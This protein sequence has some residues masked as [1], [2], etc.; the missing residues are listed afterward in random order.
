MARRFGEPGALAVSPSTRSFGAEGALTVDSPSLL[1]RRDA[2][3][4]LADDQRVER[5]LYKRT[6]RGLNRRLRK[7]DTAAGQEAIE[8]LN[9]GRAAGIQMTG[10][11]SANHDFNYAG[12]RLLDS[13]RAAAGAEEVTSGTGVTPATGTPGGT[14]SAPPAPGAPTTGA[15]G[16]AS[17]VIAGADDGGRYEGEAR[18]V[19]DRRYRQMG[20]TG[21]NP[22]FSTRT[23]NDV[24]SSPG[25]APVETETDPET[26]DRIIRDAS[27][28]VIGRGSSGPRTPAP[29]PTA[30]GA[31]V[32]SPESMALREG[33]NRTTRS[34]ELYDAVEAGTL[35]LADLDEEEKKL[36]SEGSDFRIFQRE[37]AEFG[38]EEAMSRLQNRARAGVRTES[39]DPEGRRFKS[40]TLPDIR[41]GIKPRNRITRI[42]GG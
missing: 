19:L 16:S 28:N 27:G 39:L 7:G 25:L 9:Q 4:R 41:E 23:S 24:A 36:Y 30:S 5:N 18:G 1:E 21:V 13:R 10:I 26:G 6:F 20:G 2:V 14:S 15:G 32:L 8:L 17:V 33:V 22:V 38:R 29:T 37:E 40:A 31:E 42:L 3:S 11:P 35:K 34:L 12:S